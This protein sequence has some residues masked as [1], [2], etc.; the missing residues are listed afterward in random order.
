M[1]VLCQVFEDLFA[2]VHAGFGGFGSLWGLDRVLRSFAA[3]GGFAWLSLVGSGASRKAIQ[4]LRMRL[5]S[6]L[7]QRG[8]AFGPDLMR[9]RAKALG[10]LE[11]MKGMG[12]YSRPSLRSDDGHKGKSKNKGRSRFPKGMTERKARARAAAIARARA[13]VKTAREQEQQPIQG[14]LHCG[15]DWRVRPFG[16]GLAAMKLEET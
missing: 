9:P 16:V 8:R 2:N 5:R 3:A 14:S 10:Y 6:G 4:S 12:N 1:G 7:R 13:T 11:A 15:R